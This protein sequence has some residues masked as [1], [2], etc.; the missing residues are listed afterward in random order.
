MHTIT[1]NVGRELLEAIR[2]TLYKLIGQ[3]RDSFVAHP[4]NVVT[5]LAG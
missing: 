4:N 2:C 3:Q 5:P 1:K